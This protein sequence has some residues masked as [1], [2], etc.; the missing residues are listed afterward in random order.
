MMMVARAVEMVWWMSFIVTCS[1]EV[2]GGC[3][4]I[5]MGVEMWHVGKL[6]QR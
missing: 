2:A 3:S 4:W 6:E 1:E 5:V